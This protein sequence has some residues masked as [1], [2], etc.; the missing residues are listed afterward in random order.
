MNENVKIF[1]NGNYTVICNV[2][3]FPPDRRTIVYRS[4]WQWCTRNSERYDRLFRKSW[5]K[6]WVQ[7]QTPDND[8]SCYETR[9]FILLNCMCVENSQ[10]REFSYNSEACAVITHSRE[11][12][13][14]QMK[15]RLV[16]NLWV[17]V[18][19]MWPNISQVLF[20]AHFGYIRKK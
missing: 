1:I 7:T 15:F 4:L 14:D 17:E 6:N 8:T 2:S 11:L 12:C 9:L 18:L 10:R 13:S 3:I 5:R 19:V 20:H 16:A